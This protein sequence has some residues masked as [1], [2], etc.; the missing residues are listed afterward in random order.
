[1]QSKSER[2]VSKH[3]GWRGGK[4]NAE[5]LARDIAYSIRQHYAAGT[6]RSIADYTS[7]PEMVAKVAAYLEVKNGL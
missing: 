3:R 2:Y 4:G 1:M 6:Y 5:K 7:D